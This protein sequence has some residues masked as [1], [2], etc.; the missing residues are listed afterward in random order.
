MALN[1]NSKSKRV[2]KVTKLLVNIHKTVLFHLQFC[3]L[4]HR[5]LKN[6]TCLLFSRIYQQVV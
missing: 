2:K 5:L 4:L 1:Q 6:Y 3:L